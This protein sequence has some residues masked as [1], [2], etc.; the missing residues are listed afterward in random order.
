M[1]SN[2]GMI[3]MLTKRSPKELHD[4][5]KGQEDRHPIEPEGF[6][7]GKATSVGCLG[8]MLTLGPGHAKRDDRD[9][10]GSKRNVVAWEG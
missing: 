2:E 7:E 4:S 9:I 5:Q 3:G 8:L 6:Q 10:Q 1:D